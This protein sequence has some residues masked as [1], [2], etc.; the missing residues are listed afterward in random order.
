MKLS[1]LTEVLIRSLV[2]DPDSVSVR[3]FDDEEDFITI[4]VLVNESDMG[5]VIGRKGITAQSIRTI[6][7][8]AA[9]INGEKK[10]RINIDSI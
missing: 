10:V 4:E 3:Q 9:Y 5:A 8:A 1:E 2:K 6:V 7:Q